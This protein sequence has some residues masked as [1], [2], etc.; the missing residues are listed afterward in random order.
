M[1]SLGLFPTCRL[2]LP[3]DTVSGYKVPKPGTKDH[4]I[5]NY[6]TATYMYSELE[7]TI[8]RASNSLQKKV[9]INKC[10]KIRDLGT[11]SGSP[12]HLM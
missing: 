10:I 5:R 12:S 9:V 3:P 7:E 1:S 4:F 8:Y 11:P 2:S 6:S